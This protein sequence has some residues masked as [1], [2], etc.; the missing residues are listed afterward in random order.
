MCETGTS[1]A[2]ALPSQ[3][4]WQWLGWKLISL[5]GENEVGEDDWAIKGMKLI[6]AQAPGRT[7]VMKLAN[8]R[9]N[10]QNRK[11]PR[12]FYFHKLPKNVTE[13]LLHRSFMAVGAFNKNNVRDIYFSYPPSSSPGGTHKSSKRQRRNK[14]QNFL[15]NLHELFEALFYYDG[16]ISLLSFLSAS[17][18]KRKL[19]DCVHNGFSISGII[20]RSVVIK[21]IKF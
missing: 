12:K 20:E 21:L 19:T 6:K 14:Q 2:R 15:P 17:P 9:V 8:R 18:A 11:W 5:S 10:N 16:S 4:R 3:S 7:R 1:E 13:H